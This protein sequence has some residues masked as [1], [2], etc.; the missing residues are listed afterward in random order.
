MW[1][2]LSSERLRELLDW[3]VNRLGREYTGY[4]KLVYG[5]DSYMSRPEMLEAALKGYRA[6]F[7]ALGMA[8]AQQ[9]R[10][11]FDT[12]AEFL[13]ASKGR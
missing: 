13:G 10:I 2:G 8:P 1:G 7:D 4:E 5:S 12:S 3:K 6:H 11:L 9:R